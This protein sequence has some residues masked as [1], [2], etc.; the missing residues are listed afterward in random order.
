MSTSPGATEF[1]FVLTI[2]GDTPAGPVYR[3]FDGTVKARPG[4]TAKDVY[5]QV[6]SKIATRPNMPA[7]PVVMCWSLTP[8]QLVGG[9]R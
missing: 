7:R 8:N 4:E 5:D 3:T 1:H 9:A 2:Y 6:T